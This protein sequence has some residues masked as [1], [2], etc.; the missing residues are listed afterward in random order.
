MAELVESSLLNVIHSEPGLPAT[1]CAD[2]YP[3]SI[4]TNQLTSLNDL[5]LELY[6]F[7]VPTKDTY[8]YNNDGIG[9]I[10]TLMLI[11]VKNH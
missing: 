2:N 6:N 5:D 9:K 8:L 4:N 1:S 10:L 7:L 3:I 11:K